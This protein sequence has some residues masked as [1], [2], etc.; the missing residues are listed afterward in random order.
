MRKSSVVAKA[1]AVAAVGLAV[2]VVGVSSPAD[3][4]CATSWKTYAVNIANSTEFEANT[5]CDGLWAQQADVHTDMV[6]GR[7]Y[8][9]GSWQTSDTYGW[10]TITTAADSGGKLIGNTVTDRRLRGQSQTY[11]QSIQSK[12]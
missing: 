1:A 5:G 3:A 10:K 11:T 7:F 9:E 12:Y 4:A 8:K 6:R 2:P